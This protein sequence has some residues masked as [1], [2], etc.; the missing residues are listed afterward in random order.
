MPDQPDLLTVLIVEDHQMVSEMF[1]T[2]LEA[3]GFSVVGVARTAGE[4]AALY[5]RHRPDLVLC[6]VRLDAGSSGI[7]MTKGIVGKYP[8]AK[9]LIVSAED[10][11]HVIQEALDAG[12]VGYV[13]KRASGPELHQAIRDAMSGM[14][15]V[16]DRY[17]YRRIIES[18]NAKPEPAAV[19]LTPR[20]REV[21]DLMVSGISTTAA[22]GAQL[23]ISANSVRSHVENVMRK[24][25]AHSRAEIV[26]RVFQLGLVPDRRNARR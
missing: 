15:G 25:D 3:I 16:A 13:A 17:T 10:E 26:A 8:D 2:Q 1:S 24:V 5:D 12:A 9:I 20:E 7:T 18:M 14:T 4:G 22:L 11:G 21:V 19:I 23:S 6:D